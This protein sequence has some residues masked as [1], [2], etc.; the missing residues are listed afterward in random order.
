MKT[1]VEFN[2]GNKMPIVGYGMWQAD[3]PKQLETALDKALDVGYRHFDTAFTYYNEEVF[4]KVLN[5]WFSTGKVKR[6]DL[7]IVT[8]LPVFGSHA[9]RVE[10]YLKMSLERLQLDYVDLYLIHNPACLKPTADMKGLLLENGSAVIDTSSTLEELWKAM[11]AQVKAG[12]TKSI[13]LSNF[14]AAQIERIV[15]VATIKPANIQVELNVYYQ[16]KPLRD[17]CAKHGITVCAFAPL[18]SPGRAESYKSSGAHTKV[19]IPPLLNDPVI[20][21]IAK[22]H[23]KTPAQVLLRALTQQGIVVIPKSVTPARIAENFNVFDF[24]LDADSMAAIVKLDTGKNGT[25]AFDWINGQPGIE[26]HPE[27]QLE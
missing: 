7:F 2:D 3:D 6:E 9:D 19:Q 23:N 25:W 1:H 14:S 24:E 18:G 4:G 17:V 12:R 27:F 20:L 16:K 13:G 11:E 22:K 26:K 8:K 5:R 21:E 10:P 15:K